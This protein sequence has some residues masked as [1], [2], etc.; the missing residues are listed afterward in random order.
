MTESNQEA[1][2]DMAR[3]IVVQIREY[4]SAGFEVLGIVGKNGSPT[5]GVEQ[6][7]RN[8]L[9]PGSGVFIDVLRQ[10]LKHHNIDT[11][12]WGTPGVGPSQILH[13]K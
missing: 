3:D 6:T 7:W 4:R 8:G 9:V 10:E 1:L 11:P 5:C 12:I 2:R 13:N